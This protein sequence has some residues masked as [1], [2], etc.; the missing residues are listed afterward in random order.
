MKNSQNEILLLLSKN[1]NEISKTK[2]IFLKLIFF[3]V[4]ESVKN[5]NLNSFYEKYGHDIGRAR[6]VLQNRLELL[7]KVC[8]N[9][10]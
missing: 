5:N 4:L 3:F 6:L 1:R 10:F 2:K 7:N 9:P 8:F